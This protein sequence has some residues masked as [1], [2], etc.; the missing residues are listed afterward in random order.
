MNPALLAR[1]A[2]RVETRLGR[3][4]RDHGRRRHPA[5]P[6][7]PD[8][9]RPRP[10]ERRL[11]HRGGAPRGLRR[12]PRRIRDA[13]AAEGWPAPVVADSGNGGHLLYR[14]DLP[15]DD[16]SDGAREGRPRRARRTLL[17][18]CGEGRHGELQRGADLEVLRHGRAGRATR[19]RTGRTAARRSSARPYEPEVVPASLLR[20]LAASLPD[21]TRRSG[22]SRPRPFRPAP[23][24]TSAP[25]STRHGIAVA[26]EKPWQGGTL[27]TLAQCPFSDAHADGAYAIQFPNGAVHA[28]CKHESCGGGRQRWQELRARLE[29][30]Y[31]E[32]ASRTI[33]RRTRPPRCTIGRRPAHPPPPLPQT[34]DRAAPPSPEAIASPE[35]DPAV[36]AAA[37][38]VL[39]HGDPV[40]FFLDCFEQDHVGDTMLAHCLVMSIAS[41]GGPQLARAARLRHGR[42]RARASRAA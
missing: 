5:P 3:E 24:S 30:A 37:R 34:G 20:A 42:D 4:G 6:L 7:A 15:N 14:V 27:Y 41:P 13:L 18:R 8:R 10:A 22:S 25:G 28:G 38:E 29:P 23:R 2:N 1:R 19:R 12:R 9:R 36:V 31:A 33:S 21:R 11:G 16:G 26:A 32:P 17:D 35:P 39:E 40:R